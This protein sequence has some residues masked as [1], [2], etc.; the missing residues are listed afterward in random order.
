MFHRSTNHMAYIRTQRRL[1]L[2]AQQK[3]PQMSRYMHL[4]KRQRTPLPSRKHRDSLDYDPPA[5]ETA[6]ELR[7]RQDAREARLNYELG[8]EN[9]KLDNQEAA[10]DERAV[11][12]ISV[13]VDDTQV[14]DV[15]RKIYTAYGIKG[16]Q[17]DRMA[18][19]VSELRE[20]NKLR[21]LWADD[22][23]QAAQKASA[24]KPS[25]G[26]L[27]AVCKSAE[28]DLEAAQ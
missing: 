13:L 11:L 3:L 24:A 21:K 20:R 1:R 27:Q 14:R 7:E 4:A 5:N 6:A 17:A 19:V 9:A 23:A 25:D 2:L 28:V 12:I 26:N 10:H 15:K 16:P 22:T 8:A 18:G